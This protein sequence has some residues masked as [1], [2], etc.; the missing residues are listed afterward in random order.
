MLVD[1]RLPFRAIV[2]YYCI[3]LTLPL[4]LVV[5]AVSNAGMQVSPTQV[6]VAAERNSAGLTLLNSGEAALY[7]QV[8]VYE[9]RQDGEDEQ[10]L[11]T[12]AIVASPPMLKLAPGVNQ[13]VRIVRS[14]PSPTHSE[15]SYRIIID[16]LPVN[17]GDGVKNSTEGLTFRLRYSIPVFLAP[18][19]PIVIQPILDTQIAEEKGARFLRIRNTGNGHAQ[20]VDLSWVPEGGPRVAI[21]AGLAGYI[22]P[23]QQR[24]WLLPKELN[25]R[26]GGA[27]TARVNGELRERILV[28]VAVTE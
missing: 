21:A 16:E 13:L 26:H 18:L 2:K 12:H 4:L 9:W 7:A 8:R 23:G 27:V 10:L 14:G 17:T 3:G 28:P 6:F 19:K 20:I 22:L 15:A 1:S 24:Q 5:S 25:R 11:P